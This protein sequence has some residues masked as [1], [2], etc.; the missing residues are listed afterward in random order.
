MSARAYPEL[1]PKE[2]L[3]DALQMLLAPSS[4]SEFLQRYFEREPLHIRRGDPAYFRE[5]YDV[6]EIESSIVAGAL[7]HDKFC[8]I[9]SG[10]AQIAAEEM[11]LER[12]YPRARHTG[13]KPELVLD[14]RA[15]LA[16]FTNGYTLVIKD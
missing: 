15:I 1:L 5:I 10:A 2:R 14:S 4:T 8:L 16:H 3:S 11:T 7:E 13:R 9:K 12:H 6:A